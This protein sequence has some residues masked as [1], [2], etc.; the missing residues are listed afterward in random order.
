MK[1]VLNSL[2]VSEE[3][4][5]V[6]FHYNKAHNADI[7]IPPWVVKCKGKSYYVNHMTIGEGVGF[8][9][10]ETPVS[11][12]TKAALKVKGVLSIV[13]YDDNTIEAFVE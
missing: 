6:V 11:P 4:A 2:Q 3:K 12:H 9:T 8:S 7:T 1:K 10:K 13:T 5:V